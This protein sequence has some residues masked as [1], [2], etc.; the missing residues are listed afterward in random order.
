M[1]GDVGSSLAPLLVDI[2]VGPV[3]RSGT[4]KRWVFPRALLCLV[5][6]SQMEIL[7]ISLLCGTL[8][9]NIFKAVRLPEWRDRKIAT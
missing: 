1:A 4:D 9:G 7:K 2:M 3:S 6:Y 5:S 8:Q